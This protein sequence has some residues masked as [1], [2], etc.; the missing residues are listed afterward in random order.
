M[1]R[2]ARRTFSRA[3]RPRLT[4]GHRQSLVAKIVRLAGAKILLERRFVHVGGDYASTSDNAERLV[5]REIDTAFKRRILTGAVIN[6]K[7]IEPRQF[8]EDAR[9][10]VLERV[11]DAIREHNSVKV[12][13]VFNG[14]FI[15]G[16][17]RANKSITTK[18]YELYRTSNVRE[19]YPL[20]V[21]EPILT[22][23]DE[24]EERDS[25][26]ALSRILNLMVNVN[27]LNPMHA[28]CYFE[29][30][31]VLLAKHAV[32]NVRSTDNACFARSVVAALYPVKNNAERESLYPH[33][34]E[35]LNFDGIEFPVTLKDITRFERANSV[36]INVYGIEEEKE[37]LKVLPIRLTDDKKERHVNLLYVQDPRDDNLSHYAWIKN[38][39]RLVSSQ[40]SRHKGRKFICDRYV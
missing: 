16:E 7:H 33:Y 2:A 22:S 37:S 1:H 24:F 30:P 12:N 27:K 35:V 34:A 5:W 10:I 9:E 14:E 18:N 3:K 23:L 25:G 13:T 29:V 4:V 28:G 6:S 40:L 15:S 17:K 36:S 38:L 19:W 39:S 26:W 20:R 21:I 11:G 32:I 31:Q 8:L